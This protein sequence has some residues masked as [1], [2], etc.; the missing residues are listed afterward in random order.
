MDPFGANIVAMSRREDYLRDAE[1]ER[2]ARAL[3]RGRK[4]HRQAEAR[5]EAHQHEVARPAIA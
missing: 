2:Q 3:R 1:S 4:R 5:P